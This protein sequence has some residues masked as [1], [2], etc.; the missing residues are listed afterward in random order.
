MFKFVR[1][2]TVG[3]LERFGKFQRKLEPG[4]QF[5]VPFIDKI[6]IIPTD[7]RSSDFFY[8]VKTKDDVMT[9]IDLSVLYQY[10]DP[11]KAFY[12]VSNHIHQIDGYISSIIRSSVSNIEL[13]SLCADSNTLENKI[14][15]SIKVKMGEY[16]YD[17]QSVQIKPIKPDDKVQHAMNEINASKRLKEASRNNSE[18][19]KI[20]LIAEAEADSERKR[21]NG[22]GIANM[23]KAISLGY[24]QSIDQLSKD[25]NI[26]SK[27]AYILTLTAQ[28]LDMLERIGTSQNSKT[29]F[30]SNSPDGLNNILSSFRKTLIEASETSNLSLPNQ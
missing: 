24:K 26:S 15:E 8:T 22:E 2:S 18:A 6:H 25:L 4:L 20:E 9:K 16:G 29:M 13:D 12:S 21:L 14:S 7:I 27:D 5:Y 19:K 1:T 10:K 23:R 30:L 3:L 11:E 28:Y 17:I